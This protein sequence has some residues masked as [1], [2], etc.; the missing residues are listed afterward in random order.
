MVYNSLPIA[1]LP[2]A[3]FGFSLIHFLF[4]AAKKVNVKKS[5]LGFNPKYAKFW[6]KKNNHSNIIA[7]SSLPG[8]DFFANSLRKFPKI[9]KNFDTILTTLFFYI[10]IEEK[11]KYAYIL[12]PWFL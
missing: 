5:M 1:L 9:Y 2:A 3:T 4:P 7:S 12:L 8:G 6:R 10:I 11:Y